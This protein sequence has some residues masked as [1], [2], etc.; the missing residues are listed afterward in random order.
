[1]N[2]AFS[3]EG[4]VS[5]GV[6]LT[7]AAIPLWMH[8]S[9]MEE[10]QTCIE[11]AL[12]SEKAAPHRSGR[13]EMKLYAGLAAALLHAR[14]PLP[15]G[16]IVWSKALQIAESLDDSRYLLRVL[17]GLSICRFYVGDY[18]AAL[19]LLGKFRSIASKRGDPADML[20]CDRLIATTLHYLGD[21]ARARRGLER[22]LAEH[23]APLHRSHIAR[24]QYD[25]RVAA[26][27]TLAN[28][29]WLQGLPDQAT[30]L[31]RNAVADARASGH[32]FTLC[33]ALIQGACP[34][35]FYVGDLRAAE[36]LLDMLE[37]LLT[38][39]AMTVSNALVQVLQGTLLVK[40]G[41]RAG[42]PLLWDALSELREA[43]FRLRYPA[44]LGT[45]AQGL[46]EAGQTEEARAAIDEALDWSGRKEERWCVA[47]L[48]RIKGDILLLDGSTAGIAEAE[49]TYRQALE[50]A[51]RQKAL[52][53]ALRAATSLAQL[54]HHHRRTDEATD[55]LTSVY[56]RF[57]EGFETVDLK[58]ARALIE[59]F[60][61][62]ESRSRTAS[63]T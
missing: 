61:R 32:A 26:Q 52:S 55:L 46:C 54:W 36:R 24:F 30:H 11:R 57:T 51:H 7:V 13:D 14:G 31:A 2:W 20:S 56:S 58:S 23:A 12:G 33:S 45:L 42:V 43:R 34:V 50:W 10:C 48:L 19:D 18:R 22:V 3:P 21:Q 38:K 5:I 37:D 44:H 16:D 62:D 39:Q 53:W 60:S 6:A 9:L 4:D 17:W 35:A 49:D 47:E 27:Y 59:D 8:L 41:D 63:S 25:Q 1:V 29:L 28:T 15:R 40:R